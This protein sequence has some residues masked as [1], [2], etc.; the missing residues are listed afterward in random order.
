M[1]YYNEIKTKF[2]IEYCS[3]EK[4]AVREYELV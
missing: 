4:I 2:V 1:N 3:D